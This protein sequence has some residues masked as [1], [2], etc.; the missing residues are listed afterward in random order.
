MSLLGLQDLEVFALLSPL[1]YRKCVCCNFSTKT[2][3]LTS[4][5]TR[6]M[7]RED[8]ECLWAFACHLQDW[9]S[10]RYTDIRWE[11]KHT[12]ANAKA[13]GNVHDKIGAVHLTMSKYWVF[14]TGQYFLG[15]SLMISHCLA[16]NTD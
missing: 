15:V 11:K 1:Q 7:P 6:G 12:Q 4:D 8:R 3:D 9:M 14:F 16:W 13:K 10:P 5:A 2:V